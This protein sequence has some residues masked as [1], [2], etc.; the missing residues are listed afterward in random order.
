MLSPSSHPY[1][2]LQSFNPSVKDP[3]FVVQVYIPNLSQPTSI[4]FVNDT[5]N[6]D[7]GMTL[8][9]LQ[10]NDGIVRVVRNGILADHPALDVN[11]A[12]QGEQGML[13]MA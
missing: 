13:G 5:G 2:Q 8:L 1:A 10:K 7:D 4:A 12:N 9:I 6:K 11:V 3:D